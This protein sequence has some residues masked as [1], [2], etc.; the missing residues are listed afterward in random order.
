MSVEDAKSNRMRSIFAKKYELD[1][2]IIIPSPPPTELYLTVIGEYKMSDGS[3]V[4]SEPSTEVINN[5]PKA[6]IVYWLEWA[7]S[8]VF[9]KT[10]K[11]KNCKF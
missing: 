11:A 6:E 3:T 1:R 2:V 10:L 7:S 8:G 9:K 5:R 4:F